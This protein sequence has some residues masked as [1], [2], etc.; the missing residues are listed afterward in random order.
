M[1]GGLQSAINGDHVELVTISRDTSSA[2]GVRRIE[3]RA[4]RVPQIARS[5]RA[6]TKWKVSLQMKTV[7]SLLFASTSKL[8]FII[9]LLIPIY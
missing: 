8:N 3:I 9:A 7:L 2:T 6:T 1:E 5:L 4:K